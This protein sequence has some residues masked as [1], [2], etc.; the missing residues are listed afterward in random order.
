MSRGSILPLALIMTLTI[1]LAGIG[2]STVVLE[3]VHRAKNTDQSV[4][5]YYMSD[6]GI[7]RQLYAVRKQYATL[8]SLAELK[9]AYPDGGTWKSTGDLERADPVQRITALSTSAFAVIDLFDPDN[10]TKAPGVAKVKAEWSNG[11]DC[12]SKTAGLELGYAT[13]RVG[14][15]GL[16]ETD[17]KLARA[18]MSPLTVSGL[19]TA[20]PYRVRLKAFNCSAKDVAVTLSDSGGTPVDF[21]GNIILGSEGT[22]GQATQKI[23]VTMP[24]QDILSGL[25]GGYVLFSECQLL[26]GGLGIPICP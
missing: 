10:L 22:Y 4:A 15:T 17:F 19:S 23:V 25:F 13:L 1:L 7:E 9:A 2:L 16:V 21:F 20:S 12:V 8:T 14:L 5:A 3:G 26:K 24:K 6:A 18:E 11:S